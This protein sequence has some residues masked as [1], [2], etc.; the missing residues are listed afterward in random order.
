MSRPGSRLPKSPALAGAVRST[1]TT[2]PLSSTVSATR[3]LTTSA[4]GI[5]L[6]RNRGTSTFLPGDQFF[7]LNATAKRAYHEYPGKKEATGHIQ[8]KD[9]CD[10]NAVRNLYALRGLDWKP[11]WSAVFERNPMYKCEEVWEQQFDGDFRLTNPNTRLDEI[12]GVTQTVGSRLFWAI[13]ALL[14][15]LPNSWRPGY[16]ILTGE[17]IVRAL[18]EHKAIVVS[19]RNMALP[20]S[21]YVSH[22]TFTPFDYLR[23]PDGVLIYSIDGDDT[24]KIAERIKKYAFARGINPADLDH[25]TIVKIIG[26]ASALVRVDRADVLAANICRPILAVNSSAISPLSSSSSIVPPSSSSYQV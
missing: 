18:D 8:P 25:Q 24:T 15:Y 10:V 22:H 11:W 9:L 17:D 21:K 14:G 13:Y 12:Y 20:T 5:S 7:H 1:A 4:S 26:D 19:V 23:T 16:T 3:P 2:A 6:I